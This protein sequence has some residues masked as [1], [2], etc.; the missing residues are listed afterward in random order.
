MDAGV[1]FGCQSC[2]GF[3]I[4]VLI[5]CVASA[6]IARSFSADENLGRKI[7]GDSGDGMGRAA[8]IPIQ[9][10][11]SSS[12]PTHPQWNV[13]S[14]SHCS[15]S[16]GVGNMSRK[17]TCV[18][19][20]STEACQLELNATTRPSANAVCREYA[21]CQWNAGPWGKC[22]TTCGA[23]E[24]RREVLCTNS[25]ISE[26]FKVLWVVPPEAEPCTE[27]FGCEWGSHDWGK[28]SESC[29]TGS[30]Q[31]DVFCVN[32]DDEY[33]AQQGQR[34]E[35]ARNCSDFTKCS[36][37]LTEWSACSATCGNGHRTREVSCGQGANQ[38]FCS[39]SADAKPNTKDT[40]HNSSGCSW[41]VGS[42]SGCS[43]DCGQGVQ[44]RNLSCSS[45]QSSDCMD[46]HPPPETTRSCLAMSGCHWTSEWS[47]CSSSCGSGTKQRQVRKD[48]GASMIVDE[49]SNKSGCEW[50]AGQW[51]SCSVTCG[52]GEQRR[53]VNCSSTETDACV[54]LGKRP[55][56]RRACTNSHACPGSGAMSL[57]RCACMPEDPA[58][59]AA[60]VTNALAAWIVVS[61]VLCETVGF[62]MRWQ[63]SREV[64]TFLLSPCLIFLGLLGS[65]IL[66]VPLSPMSH[67]HGTA[68]GPD[69]TYVSSQLTLG[70]VS[71]VLQATA[72]WCFRKTE[73]G[74]ARKCWK[75]LWYISHL[76]LFVAYSAVLLNV[77]AH[78]QNRNQHACESAHGCHR[79]Q[80]MG[81]STL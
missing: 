25:Q 45:S 37:T 61:L 79:I 72:L 44:L 48:D 35:S 38:S 46:D 28:C 67:R 36:W 20:N 81:P 30:Q 74:R 2:F 80:H 52:R 16:C 13:S 65:W 29:G 12:S 5:I 49:C 75:R 7:S 54:H 3:V 31:R 40:C 51:G 41:Q 42:W 69:A 66:L 39:H 77:A 22:S 43:T 21:G 32:G 71:C 59:A 70:L 14:W 1:N 73:L 17:V 8:M 57:P 10:L 6:T 4:V 50:S 78:L 9:A 64:L 15:A 23:G 76:A 47:V 24:R 68:G 19:G 56:E 63:G 58:M 55:H 27:I 34:P 33:C 60:G 62:R 53:S 26:C 11:P 18:G